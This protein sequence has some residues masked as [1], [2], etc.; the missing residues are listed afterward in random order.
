M[1]LVIN[2]GFLW[3]GFALGIVLEIIVKAILDRIFRIYDG[4]FEPGE[5]HLTIRLFA[6]PEDVAKKKKIILRYTKKK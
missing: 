3:V 5:D 2:I 4:E 6:K 1:A